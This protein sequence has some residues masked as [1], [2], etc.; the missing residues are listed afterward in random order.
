MAKAI[1]YTEKDIWVRDHC[2]IRGKYKGSAH[3]DCHV[4]YFQLKFVEMKI[5]VI[6]HDL[7]GYDSHFIV[8]EIGEIANKY[9]YKSKKGKTKRWI[10]MAFQTTWKN[11][12]LFCWENIWVFLDSFR[13]ISSSLE[14]LA[15]N[16][17]HDA[18]R[19]TSEVF[20]DN[21]LKLMKQNGV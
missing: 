2:H 6:F 19:Y 10:S 1:F 21:E 11:T 9:T 4:N 15:S 13:F 14:R 3:E 7:Q 12:W 5:P 20:K 17:S 8:Q 18:Y 16:F